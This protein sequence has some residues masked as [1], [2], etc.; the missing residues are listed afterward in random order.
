MNLE[1]TVPD[2]NVGDICSDLSTRRGRQTGSES[3]GGGMQVIKAE[4]PLAEVMTY[5]RSLASM[6]GGQGVTLSSSIVMTLFRNVQAQVIAA[7][8]L[9]EDEE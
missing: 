6:T 2:D 9:Q 7:A 8:D 5:S 3:A 1:V 4:I